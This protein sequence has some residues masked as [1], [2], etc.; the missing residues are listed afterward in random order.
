MVEAER[1]EMRKLLPGPD[2]DETYNA[3][4]AKIR[5][6]TRAE[7]LEMQAVLAQDQIRNLEYDAQSHRE[8]S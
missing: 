6:Q 4:R 7:S 8:E 2:Q 1:D 5:L 3:I